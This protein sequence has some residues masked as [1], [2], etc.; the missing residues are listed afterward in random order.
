MRHVPALSVAAVVVLSGTLLCVCSAPAST[1]TT[2][3]VDL[4]EALSSPRATAREDPATLRPGRRGASR[5]ELRTE[6]TT[7][8]VLEGPAPPLEHSRAILW[9]A[10]AVPAGV[11]YRLVIAI[12]EG[13]QAHI[14]LLACASLFLTGLVL[15]GV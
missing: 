1:T 15:V 12:M 6:G 2:A 13:R 5:A 7:L 3:A 10:L 11:G 9:L 14:V 4:A 8:V